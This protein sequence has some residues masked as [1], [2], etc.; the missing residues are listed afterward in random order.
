M[1]VEIILFTQLRYACVFDVMER[2]YTSLHEQPSNRCIHDSGLN[3][4]SVRKIRLQQ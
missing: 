2:F 4:F 1:R 3:I